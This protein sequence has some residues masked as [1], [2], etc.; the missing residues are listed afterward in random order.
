[1]LVD[2]LVNEIAIFPD[3]LEVTVHGAPRLNMLLSELGLA[4]QSEN[5]CVGGGT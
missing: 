4:D 5:A 3:H 2:E 1:M